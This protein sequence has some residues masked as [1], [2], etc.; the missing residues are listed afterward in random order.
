MRAERNGVGEYLNLFKRAARD[1]SM[2]LRSDCVDDE[3][4]PCVALTSGGLITGSVISDVVR[5]SFPYTEKDVKVRYMIFKLA[6]GNLTLYL[7]L[8][9]IAQITEKSSTEYFD[10]ETIGDD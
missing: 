9:G 7:Y 2:N 3:G 10:Q 4:R 6:G 1:C 5:N 8:R